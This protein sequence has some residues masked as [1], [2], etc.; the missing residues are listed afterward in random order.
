MKNT[1]TQ[2]HFEAIK[3]IRAQGIALEDAKQEHVRNL[4]EIVGTLPPATMQAIDD[5]ARQVDL[6]YNGAVR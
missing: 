4:E 3:Y 6:I 1:E 2:K 5:A